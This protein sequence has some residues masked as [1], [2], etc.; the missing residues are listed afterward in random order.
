MTLEHIK[1]VILILLIILSSLLT[2]TIWT[3]Q[4]NYRVLEDEKTVQGVSLSGEERAIN[5]I[6][7]PGQVYCHFSNVHYGTLDSELIERMMKEI[8]RWGYDHFEEISGELEDI[9]DF[10][11]RNGMTEIVFP[12]SVPMKVFRTFA[13]VKDKNTS[14]IDFDR[15]VIDTNH[16]TKSHGYVYF[17]STENLTVYR[18]EVPASLVANFREQFYLPSV[19]SGQ[20]YPHQMVTLENGNKLLVRTAATK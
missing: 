7:F 15:L 1:T 3:Y 6:V 12:A 10:I 17:V 13:E 16:L 2:W 4:P 19:Q 9:Y 11:Y 20:F 8:S 18:S 14:T 5:E